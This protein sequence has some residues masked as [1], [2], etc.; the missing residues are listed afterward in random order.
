M[1][2]FNSINNSGVP[3]YFP[4][5]IAKEGQQYARFSNWLKTRVSDNGKKVPVKWYDQ[6]R[7]MNVNGLTPFIEGMVGHFTTDENDELMPSSDV[8]S[9][10][11]QGSPADVTDGGLAF[12]TLE[13]QFF[14]QAGQFKGVFGLRDNN[15]NVYTSVNIV[16]EILGN[17]L[18]IGETT[19]YYS[20]K[21]DKMV[22]EFNV[23]TD[24]A[25]EDLYEKYKSK[26]QKAEDTVND[27]QKDMDTTNLALN[28]VSLSAKA[29]QAQ[30]DSEDLEKA[31]D[32]KADIYL[33]KQ[34]IINRFGQLKHPT[35]VFD[36][37]TQLTAKYPNG[38]DGSM[39]T[40]DNGHMYVFN[41]N[42]NTWKDFGVFQAQGLPTEI[43]EALNKSIKAYKILL[44]EINPPYDNLDT[45]PANQVVTYAYPTYSS[46][47]RNWPVNNTNRMAT[48]F[49]LS[50]SGNVE[51]GGA[52]QM[53]FFDSGEMQYRTNW[54]VPAKYNKWHG[55][56]LTAQVI[57]QHIDS[58]QP[59]FNDLNELYENTLICYS[60]DLDK[61][62]NSPVNNSSDSSGLVITNGSAI[63]YGT[64]Q[65][66][67]TVGG[68][69]YWRFKWYDGKSWIPWMSSNDNEKIVSK[70]QITTEYQ[71]LH[72]IQ[73]N[74]SV[75]YAISPSVFKTVTNRPTDNPLTIST[76]SGTNNKTDSTGQVQLAVDS[77]GQM[78]YSINWYNRWTNWAKVQTEKQIN[79]DFTSIALFQSVGIIGD[80]YASGEL[81]I[82][83]Y[84][85]HYNI[86]WGQ[87]LAR[88]NGA[89]AV[90]YSRGGQ[91][92]RGWLQD[93]DRGL[94]LLQSA[95][96]QDLY[97]LALGI[98]DY[99][100]LGQSYLGS[101]DDIGTNNDTFYGN[102]SKIIQAV[103]DKAPNSK[104]VISTLSQTGQ[105]PDMFTD[106]I[107]KIAQHFGIP[108][109][110]LNSDPFF[111]SDF[112]LNHLHGGHPTGPIYAGMAKGYERLIEKAMITDLSYF[113]NY[114]NGLD[115]DNS[116]DLERI[117]GE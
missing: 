68:K 94:G 65:I 24:Q 60:Y 50:A 78:F 8:V 61:L 117:K 47:V 5:D 83:K 52:V 45:L 30:I 84:T 25:V 97:I 114:E 99:G 116:S 69:I 105:L 108:C 10:D 19:K 82:D 48:V 28:A 102:Y 76:F 91:T 20:S 73:N 64:T 27:I 81:A 111:T 106:A 67:I 33:L 107:K 85:D 13:D 63:E 16:F 89:T 70:G 59:P 96:A 115:S 66:M 32:H 90:N 44:K 77:T 46:K 101:L 79:N 11:W 113:E 23:R 9:R 51:D 4:A 49:T 58:I 6:G 75:T 43:T 56:P 98:N 53:I 12:Y 38:A 57:Q 2:N 14:C 100:K 17:D 103:K 87:I 35:Q 40:T 7:V 41:W 37:L 104:I 93:Q 71:D 109:L 112:Y 34:D 55:L 95:P 18:R 15:G 62:Q 36:S 80:S 26:A 1:S 54:G 88:K 21:L 3:Y 29:L 110:E 42:T 31:E 92:T 74:K 72:K 22:Q 39:L 86:S